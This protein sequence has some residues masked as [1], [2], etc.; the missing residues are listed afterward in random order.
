MI[1]KD[2]ALFEPGQIQCECCNAKP[3]DGWDPEPD[4]F[5]RCKETDAIVCED[6][7]KA[8]YAEF[9]KGGPKQ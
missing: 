9:L 1:T 4:G 3:E 5:V 6:C 7:L 2:I 8:E